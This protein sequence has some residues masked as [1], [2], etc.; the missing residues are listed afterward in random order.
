MNLEDVNGVEIEINLKDVSRVI[1][2]LRQI[3]VY[4]KDNTLI[5]VTASVLNLL[6]LIDAEASQSCRLRY[7]KTSRSSMLSWH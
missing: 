6:R 4:T 7:K 3:E 5:K 1:L 2:G